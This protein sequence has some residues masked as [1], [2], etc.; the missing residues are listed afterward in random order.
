V[1]VLITGISGAG[2]SALLR[3]LARRG[4]RTVDTGYSEYHETVD[5]EQLWREDRIAALL[6]DDG[7]WSASAITPRS[8]STTNTT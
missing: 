2:K 6:A 8:N 4:Y 5:G 7:P 3:E 1:R